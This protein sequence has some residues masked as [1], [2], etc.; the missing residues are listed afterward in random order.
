MK[1]SKMVCRRRENGLVVF[2]RAKNCNFSRREKT[3]MIQT[4]ILCAAR[5]FSSRLVARSACLKNSKDALQKTR[6]YTLHRNGAP[7]FR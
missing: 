3:I 6:F 1:C 4:E 5:T 2:E 7:R